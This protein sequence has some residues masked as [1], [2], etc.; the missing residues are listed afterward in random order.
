M[1]SAAGQW[2]IPGGRRSDETC[3]RVRGSVECGSVLC[4]RRI[5]RPAR[6][7]ERLNT[8]EDIPTDELV[9]SGQLIGTISHNYREARFGEESAQGW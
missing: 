7:C 3:F 1:V 9:S 5:R 6:R 2:T 4:S 8:H